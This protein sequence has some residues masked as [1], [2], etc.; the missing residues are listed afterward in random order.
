M[1]KLNIHFSRALI[2][3]A[4]ISA[5]LFALLIAGCAPRAAVFAV[6]PT[7]TPFSPGMF[8]QTAGTQSGPDAAASSLADAAASPQANAAVATIVAQTLQAWS[9]LPTATPV[10]TLTDT[11]DST[12]TQPAPPLAPS[13]TPVVLDAACLSG[14]WE[15]ANL[16]DAIAPGQASEGLAVQRV[17]GR[18]EYRFDPNGSL[19]ITFDQLNTT[20]SGTMN[21][22]SVSAVETFNGSAL[23]SYQVDPP[24]QQI[25]LSNFGGEGILV[26]LDINGQRLA[27]GNLPAWQA[28]TSGPGSPQEGTP[29]Q[30]SRAQVTCSGSDLTLRVLDPVGGPD[31]H[32]IRK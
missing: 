28:F 8:P 22:R 23:A 27:E 4:L 32:L 16:T 15:V 26:E 2:C 20:L 21:K 1:H 6:T 13:S 3:A 18:V 30:A 14:A 12:P 7:S 17:D 10:S 5:S 11:P 29:V 19:T 9:V 24:N 25:I 31:L